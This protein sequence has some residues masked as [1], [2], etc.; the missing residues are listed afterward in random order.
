MFLLFF[1]QLNRTLLVK[2]EEDLKFVALTRPVDSSFPSVFVQQTFLQSHPLDR[3]HSFFLSTAPVD[4]EL[5]VS[6][7]S[8]QSVHNFDLTLVLPSELFFVNLPSVDTANPDQRF[9]VAHKT[10]AATVLQVR[11]ASLH[12]GEEFMQRV[13]LHVATKSRSAVPLPRALFS[14]STE[15]DGQIRGTADVEHSRVVQQLSKTNWTRAKQAVGASLF[16]RFADLLFLQQLRRAAF[17][18]QIYFWGKRLLSYLLIFVVLWWVSRKVK[19]AEKE[20]KTATN[21]RKSS[22]Y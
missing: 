22:R 9:L 13:L 8:D 18:E 10:F 19:G 14:F 6:N 4:L 1:L 5:C 16:V 11:K 12:P 20:L 3:F 17:L 15:N 7:E 21:K 2:L